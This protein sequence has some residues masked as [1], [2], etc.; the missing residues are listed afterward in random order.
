MP[1][2]DTSI[3]QRMY[4]CLA[5]GDFQ[6]LRDEVFTPDVTWDLPGRSVLAGRMKGVDQ[7]LAFFRVIGRSGLQVEP[8]E[9]HPITEDRII[10]T[11]RV[12]GE[13]PG[14]RR[15]GYTATVYQLEA[16]K[17]AA[18]EDYLHDQHEADH[19]F[20]TVFALKPIPDR[21]A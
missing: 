4:Q 21:L 5:A 3:I 18:V 1:L 13:V 8:L 11:H 19:Y 10:E 14:A 16:G 6:S 12:F 2:A 17:I 15:D 7:V 9:M 20:N